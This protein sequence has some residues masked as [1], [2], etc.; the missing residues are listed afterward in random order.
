VAI[1]ILGFGRTAG[2]EQQLSL[3][4]VYIP[5]PNA[6]VAPFDQ[7]QSVGHE[8]EGVVCSP[9]LAVYCG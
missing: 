8:S 1:R 9:G 6:F 5:F 2:L 7:S 4:A 3:H